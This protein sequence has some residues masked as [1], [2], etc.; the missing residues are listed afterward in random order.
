MR[1]LL[2][3]VD[4]LLQP[5]LEIAAVARAGEQ[6]A[7]V[8]RIDHG[9]LQHVGHVA[10][11]DLA[12]QAFRDRRLADARIAHIE[13]VV[14]RPAAQDLHR[15]VHLRPAADQRIDLAVAGLL[16]E[17]DGELLERAFALAG[18]FRGLLLFLVLGAL[19]RGGFRRGHALA[20]AMADVADGIEAA[21]VLLL[22]EIDGIALAFGEQRDEHVCA[23]HFIAAGGLDVQDRAL[24]D[25]LEAAGGRGVGLLVDLQCA[26]L[27]V[28]IV[29]DRG[30][31]LAEI[32]AARG[33]HLAGVLVIDE[34]EQQV[35]ER[36][37]FLTPG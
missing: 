4:D 3:L 11:D 34:R 25:A 29:R 16:V 19:G 21:H 12:R 28:E 7:H 22:Q 18:L 8:E 1:H 14:L 13:R 32:D 31:E 27:G 37:I 5:L 24:D 9:G 23:G 30:L 17:V 35:F 26:E 15:A 36:G 10:L 6:R 2:E 20:D 33:H